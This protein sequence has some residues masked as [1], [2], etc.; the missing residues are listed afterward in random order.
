ME[1]REKL[2]NVAEKWVEVLKRD[3]YEEHIYKKSECRKMKKFSRVWRRIFRCINL[4]P[5][6]RNDLS[7]FEVGCGGCKHLV[8]F[9][10]NGWKC[11][12]IDC[13]EEVLKR[14]KNYIRE[15]SRICRNKLDIELIYGDFLNYIPIEEKFDIVFHVGVLEHFLNLKERMIA[16]KKMFDLTKPGGYVISIVPNGIHPLRKEMKEKGLG[17][18][19]IPEIDYTPEL[20]FREMKEFGR[21]D[22]HIFGHNIFSYLLLKKSRWFLFKKII[23]LIWQIIPISLLPSK[24][25]FRK[26]GTLIAI[27]KK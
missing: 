1:N 2:T 17:G 7:I 12:G 20:L 8:Q 9:A 26:A 27:A 4:N 18:Y 13:S 25:I 14:A 6:G 3:G 19:F 15:I 10:L 23:Y 24:F 22:I 5:Y 21:R 16:L 11:V